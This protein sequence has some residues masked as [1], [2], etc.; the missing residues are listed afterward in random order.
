VTTGQVSL[1]GWPEGTRLICRRE[2]ARPGA[3][4]SFTD[5]D[6]H[7]F[8]CFITDQD[9][10]DLAAL[11]AT[12][13][14][15]AE[16]EDRVKTLKVSGGADLP[17]HF[18][19]AYAAWLELALLAHEIMVFTQLMVLDGEHLSASPCVCAT[20]SCTSPGSLPDTGGRPLHLPV[21]WPGAGAI[22][23]AFKRWLHCQLTAERRDAVDRG[24][25]IPQTPSA[26]A[27]TLGVIDPQWI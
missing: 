27:S 15:N 22:L 3:Q 26:E 9:E 18:F 24:S 5:V 23:R 17:F 7:R 2:R 16:V 6:G 8:Q 25:S 21:D 12:H 10:Q 20:A 1:E 19:Q 11:E 4:L 14:A 13:S